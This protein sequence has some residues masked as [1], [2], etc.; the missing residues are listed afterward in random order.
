MQGLY[1]VGDWVKIRDDMEVNTEYGCLTYLEGMTKYAG[2][3]R[4]ITA[5][6][7]EGR[8]IRLFGC[9]FFWSDEML[10]PK[11]LHLRGGDVILFSD[12]PV[13]WSS[14]PDGV[15]DQYMGKIATIRDD[16]WAIED[17]F[18]IEGDE[19]YFSVPLVADKLITRQKF[20]S[21]AANAADIK[22]LRKILWS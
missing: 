8:L 16:D 13:D 9:A 10:I 19:Y 1:K 2:T 22:E 14:M 6:E 3:Y 12:N 4:R 20:E 5:L 11:D 7:N 18:Q 17:F 15:R 21:A